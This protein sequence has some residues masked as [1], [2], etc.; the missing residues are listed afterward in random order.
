MS[1]TVSFYQPDEV[2]WL[3]LPE[4]D[5]SPFTSTSLQ[6]GAGKVAAAYCGMKEIP[7][8][9]FGGWHHGW[10]AK[11]R[12]VAPKTLLE[13]GLSDPRRIPTYVAQL[14]HEKYLHDHGFAAK[15][16]GLPLAYLPERSYRRQPGSLLVMPAHTLSYTKHKWRFL[17]YVDAIADI[18]HLFS[19]V[20]VCLH[21][22]CIDN[23]YWVSEFRDQG[24]P[25]ITGADATDRN[26]L[27]R[28]RALMSQFEFV[29][30]NSYGSCLAYASFF[31][32]KV[33]IYGPYA[34]YQLEDF[35]GD[36]Y[37]SL[38]PE[39]ANKM[40]AT[41][42]E[43]FQRLHLDAFFTHPTEARQRLAWGREECGINN[44]VPPETLRELFRWQGLRYRWRTAKTI[45][46][47]RSRDLFSNRRRRNQA[48]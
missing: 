24:F 6:Y 20:V 32:A 7:E 15:A 5:Y 22:A 16:I 46:V 43:K 19:D 35:A 23:G 17:E 38:D 25:V 2:K 3:D 42:T 26:S 12:I 8:K 47:T 1:Y 28:T 37:F 27:E 48:A 45:M 10:H 14:S 13:P 21:Q 39:Y 30:T 40:F 9:I 44:A 18:R 29:T 36:D 33:S 34:A 31:G 4:P 41:A 11:H